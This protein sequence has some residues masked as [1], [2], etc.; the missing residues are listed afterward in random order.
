MGDSGKRSSLKRFFSRSSSSGSIK[1]RS[2][3]SASMVATRPKLKETD[4][5]LDALFENIVDLQNV[6]LKLKDE[7]KAFLTG[8]DALCRRHES[9]LRRHTQRV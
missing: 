8:V 9:A 7:V 2:S 3:S 4:Q 6:L 1:R 5:S